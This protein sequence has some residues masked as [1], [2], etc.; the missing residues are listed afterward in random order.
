MT[1][2][3]RKILEVNTRGRDFVIGDL[4]GCYERLMAFLAFVNFDPLVDRII[5][6]GDLADRGP[7]S[8]E[9]Y[10]LLNEP[11]FFAVQGNHEQMIADFLLGGPYAPFCIQNG[12]RWVSKYAY[13]MNE[14]ESK[15][16]ARTARLSR[17]LPLLLTV[18]M[19]NG[20]QFHVIH[21][22][23]DSNYTLTD[24][25][26]EN[27]EV[28]D[29][30]AFEQSMDGDFI[31]WGRRLFYPWYGAAITP[32]AIAEYKEYYNKTELGVMFGPELSHIYCGHSVVTQPLTIGG[33]TN[34][35][36]G[37][38]YSY[39]PERNP[40]AGLTATEP[41]TGKFWIT[42]SEGTKETTNVVI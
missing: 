9:C 27:Q 22:E 38:F 26:L 12:G 30:I 33:Q 8:Y 13:T 5:S 39:N 20:K 34:L 37:A 18:P 16:V 10:L 35:D 19:T 15:E 24:A 25:D 3:Y 14:E 32:E 23:L 28:F 36:T 7:M 2:K 41:L 29:E 11:W 4:H 31:I 1:N 42:N 6:V 40:W 21:A 17:E